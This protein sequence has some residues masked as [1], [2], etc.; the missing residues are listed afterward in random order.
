MQC[1]DLVQG[2]WQWYGRTGFR[3]E[4]MANSN[5]RMHS[6]PQRSSQLQ[7]PN[8]NVHE[9]QC[10]MLAN[11]KK[12]ARS[13]LLDNH[14]VQ[15]CEFGKTAPLR[16]LHDFQLLRVTALAALTTGRTEVTILQKQI[17]V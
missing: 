17:G 9:I 5:L 15:L 3:G 16:P 2:R 12:E 14:T 11:F 7:M 8:L 1:L 13:S 6:L 10:C 4:K